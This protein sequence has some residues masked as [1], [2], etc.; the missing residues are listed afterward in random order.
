M[1]KEKGSG[2]LGG[3]FIVV[4]GIGLLWY[5]E[6]RTVKATRGIM[7]AE[8]EFIEVSNT[9]IDSKNDGKLVATSGKLILPE[10]EVTDSV[11]GVSAKTAKLLRKVETYQ[12]KENCT[13][14]DNNK[15]TC[16]Y[17]KEWDEGITDSSEFK[18][19]GH[20]NPS[21]AKYEERIFTA[22]PVKVEEFELNSDQVKRLTAN[23]KITDLKDIEEDKGLHKSSYYY[24]DVKEDTPEI[25]NVRISFYYNNYKTVS[26]LAVQSDNSFNTYVSKTGYKINEV[27]EGKHSGKE[28]LQNLSNSNKTLKWILRI[29]GTFLIIA[30]LGSLISPLQRLAN[31]IPIIGTIFGWITGL[32]TFLVGLA[33][34]LIVI[35]LAWFRYRPIMSICIIAAGVGLYVLSRYLNKD[36]KI[37]EK[38]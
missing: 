9:K 33:I 4:L 20:E 5:N 2:I 13:T 31:Y 7:Q 34:S 32:A 19:S 1:K 3:L 21:E 23:E 36:K 27:V 22:D 30:G 17:K 12:W 25:G 37:E 11:F 29:A 15:E 24:T 8:K 35:A 28:I 18:E 10:E 16:T 38:Q 6:G 14:D 26:V